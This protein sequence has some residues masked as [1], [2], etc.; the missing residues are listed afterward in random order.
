MKNLTDCYKLYNGVNI[1]CLA[2]GTWK[3]PT[4]IAEKSVLDA[5]NT[6]YRHIDTAAIY[7]N[8][9]AV[10]NAIKNSNINRNDIFLT[11]KLWNHDQGYNS[12]LKAFNTSLKKLN[13]D[14]LDLYLIHW[15]IC[16]GHEHDWQIMVLETWRAFEKLYKEKYIRAIGVSNFM[17]KHLRL[18]LDHCSI[19]P[20][21]DQIEI[22]PGLNHS[23]TVDF[24][25]AH[26]IIV[27]GW[28]PLGHGNIFQLFDL[29]ELAKKYNKSV[30]QICLRW[31]LQR[32]IL[33][34]PKSTNINRIK[35]NTLIF[36]FE[37]SPDDMIT[38]NNLP[39]MADT[40]GADPDKS[41]Y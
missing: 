37:L 22:H 10:G 40:L 17:V 19:R 29:Q 39:Q 16:K 30:A 21:I 33:P 32:Q 24:A 23:E 8:E 25:H 14:Y 27:E 18:L 15:P 11:S 38:L 3:T 5:L 13:T 35:E 36:D 1:P 12:T 7:G 34:L 6:G 41:I 31:A 20:M 28:S 4:D 9:E 2:Y 26:D